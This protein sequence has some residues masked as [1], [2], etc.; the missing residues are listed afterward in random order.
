MQ[1]S[2]DPVS[3]GHLARVPDRHA[4]RA[5]VL[6]NDPALPAIIGGS[7]AVEQHGETL[8]FLIAG[9][10]GSQILHI[11]P[12]ESFR[13]ASDRIHA[14]LVAVSTRAAYPEIAP[15]ESE[16]AARDSRTYGS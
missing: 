4:I 14:A 12:S 5:E 10:H 1:P 15:S 3:R 6:L 16:L 8:R 2:S 9:T 7:I 11:T 13:A